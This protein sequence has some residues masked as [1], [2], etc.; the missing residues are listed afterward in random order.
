MGWAVI[1]AAAVRTWLRALP[2][3]AEWRV[4]HRRGTR[5]NR[6]PTSAAVACRL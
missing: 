3:P 2:R 4:C 6:Q 5:W 1:A